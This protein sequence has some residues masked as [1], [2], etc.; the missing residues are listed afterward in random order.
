MRTKSSVCMEPKTLDIVLVWQN[1][2]RG[3]DDS[4]YSN[5]IGDCVFFYTNLKIHLEILPYFQS[6]HCLEVI[7]VW[8]NKNRYHNNTGFYLCLALKLEFLW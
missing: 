1:K 2:T 6:K 8:I 5:M 3:P 7:L 4:T